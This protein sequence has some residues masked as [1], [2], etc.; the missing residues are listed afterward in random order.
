MM[1]EILILM[2]LLSPKQI[3]DKNNSIKEGSGMSLYLPIQSIKKLQSKEYGGF[4][5][6]LLAA[7]GPSL[8]SGAKAIYGGVQSSKKK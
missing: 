3:K 4:I 5:G 8:I 7:L 6:T 2:N 1:L